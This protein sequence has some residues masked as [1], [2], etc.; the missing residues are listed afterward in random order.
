M[1]SVENSVQGTDIIIKL[2][3]A[4][5]SDDWQQMVCEIDNQLQLTNDVTEKDSKCGTHIGIKPT[6]G[7]ISGNAVHNTDPTSTEISYNGAVTWQKARQLLEFEYVNAAYTDAEGNAVGEGAEI[8]Q[9]GTAYFTDTT[10][11]GNNGEV[12]EFSF[13]LKPVSID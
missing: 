5:T 10:F 13:T 8:S 11:K 12:S 7:N 3:E 1:A 9:T 6:K 2:R 4:G